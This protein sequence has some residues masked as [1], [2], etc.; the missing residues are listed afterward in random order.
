MSKKTVSLCM[1]VKNEEKYLPT[2]LESVKG[3]V[4]EIIIVDTGSTDATVSIAEQFG[5]KVY[6]FEWIQDFAAARNHGLEQATSEYILVLDADEYLD[7]ETDLQKDLE[8]GK[9]Y[10][11]VRIKNYQSNDSVVYHYNTRLFKNREDV[12]Y[13]GQLHENVNTYDESLG[14]TGGDAAFLIH[15]VGYMSDVVLEK[16]KKN[17]NYDII[18]KEAEANPTGYNLMNLGFS[19]YSVGE[20]EKAL[21]AFKRSYQL[22]KTKSYVKYL[23]VNIANCLTALNKYDDA[24]SVLSDASNIYTNYTDFY[25]SLGRVYEA[26][27]F[28]NDAELMYKK[29]ISIGETK[30]VFNVEGTGS[31]L[32]YYRL[33]VVYARQLRY[34][35]AFEAAFESISINKHH[36]P[37][38]VLYLNMMQKAHIPLDETYEHLSKVYPFTSLDD[39]KTLLYALYEARHP[40]FYRYIQGDAGSLSVDFRVVAQQYSKHYGAARLEWNNVEEISDENVSDAILLS[41]LLQDMSLLERCRGA[42]NFSQ[43]EWKQ[44]KKIILREEGND[45][46]LSPELEK[47][48]LEL[49]L[50]LIVLEEFDQFEYLSAFVMKGSL[51]TQCALAR[52]LHE[53]GYTDTAIEILLP[54]LETHPNHVPL[55]QLL[56]DICAAKGHLDDATYLYQQLVNVNKEYPSYQRLYDVYSKNGNKQGA[57]SIKAEMKKLYPLSIHVKNL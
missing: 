25:Y 9:D 6:H 40:L 48:L 51:D 1:I 54:N 42:L 15:H 13:R 24:I 56:G 31:F 10:Y 21:D 16:D 38:V 55:V 39:M 33:G 3:K 17:R 18:V 53:Y 41:L 32:A 4:D 12:R 2:C 50:H 47:I 22:S 52:I 45:K 57:E 23:I 5:A 28:S 11:R 8:S 36:R 43:R 46:G 35:E 27:G 29:C 37:A 14:L 20:F 34:A 49:C 19:Y 30:D 44:L 7:K 26:K